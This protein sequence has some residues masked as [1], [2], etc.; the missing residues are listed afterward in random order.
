MANVPA[1]LEETATWEALPGTH[2]GEPVVHLQ[3]DNGIVIAHVLEARLARE[4]AQLASAAPEMAR[5]L[6]AIEWSGPEAY[7]GAGQFATCPSCAGLDPSDVG[8]LVAPADIAQRGC[9]IG[10]TPSCELEAAI[11]KAGLR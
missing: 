10:H 1:V 6:L 11:R 5:L 3:L 8:S 7:V 4:R 2:R 9:T